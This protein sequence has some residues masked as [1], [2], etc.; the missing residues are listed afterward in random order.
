MTTG[1]I[2]DAGEIDNLRRHIAQ[3]AY[4][5]S[6]HM[7]RRGFYAEAATAIGTD[8]IET[9]GELASRILKRFPQAVFFGGQLVFPDESWLTRLPHNFIVFALQRD[10]FR[11]G[12]PFLI[13]P[14]RV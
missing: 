2:K 6:E 7:R 10:I 12:I 5:Y 13:V 1:G 4:R 9:T 14:I 3:E 11:Q 8:V